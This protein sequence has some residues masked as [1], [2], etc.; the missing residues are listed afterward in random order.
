MWEQSPFH[1]YAKFT[2]PRNQEITFSVY[3][4]Q[5][6]GVQ[7]YNQ[8]EFLQEFFKNKYTPVGKEFFILAD[9]RRRI[10]DVFLRTY[11][12]AVPQQWAEWNYF[13]F[14]N[15]LPAVVWCYDDNPENKAYLKE[16]N[17]FWGGPV[18]LSELISEFEREIQ[19]L[20]RQ[21]VAENF[22]AELTTL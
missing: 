13:R 16:A 18:F 7:N 22:P 12:F 4:R 11:D 17:K 14:G 19:R 9:D 20:Y 2:S 1:F 21:Y 15:P 8:S 6:P 10:Y 3:H 5:H